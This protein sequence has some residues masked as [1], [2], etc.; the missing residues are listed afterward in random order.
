MTDKQEKEK[1]RDLEEGARSADARFD[2]LEARLEEFEDKINERFN[3]I[4]ESIDGMVT[5]VRMG[6]VA[7]RVLLWVSG[8]V[9]SIGAFA[10]WV[11]IEL[12]KIGS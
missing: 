2:R 3:E 5:E 8:I 11:W 12:K 7:L 1:V 6:R 4:N 10:A 9:G